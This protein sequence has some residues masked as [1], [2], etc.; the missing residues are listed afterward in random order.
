MDDLFEAMYV[1]PALREAVSGRAWVQA[2]LDFEAA[3]AARARPARR[4]PPRSPPP[5]GPST[6]TYHALAEAGR[7]TGNPAAP[8]VARLT[9]AVGDEAAGWVHVGAT[10]QDVL[11]TASMLV[12]RRALQVVGTELGAVAAACAGLAE[13]HRDTPMAGRTLL[14]QALPTTFGLKA[15]GW[16]LGVLAARR[17]LADG[18]AGR[19]ARRRSGNARLPGGRRPPRRKGA[20]R[21][22][23]AGRAR[24]AVARR[25][26]PGGRAGAPPSRWP[27]ARW[28][29]SRST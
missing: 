26:R 3:L 19:A 12:S 27:P 21:A 9:E 10:S 22:A 7:S 17:R 2:M 16:L 20:G 28:R 23:R 13:E 11:D 6:S 24:A 29:R 1:P 5:A 15:T 14:Q 25:P 18:A 8:L 4:R